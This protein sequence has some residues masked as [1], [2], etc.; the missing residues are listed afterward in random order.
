MKR[1]KLAESHTPEPD[2][3][4]RSISLCSLESLRGAGFQE[5]LPWL[6]AGW[7]SSIKTAHNKSAN[8]PIAF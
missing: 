3:L 1:E 5:R 8:F 4:E 7:V 6:G 2:Y